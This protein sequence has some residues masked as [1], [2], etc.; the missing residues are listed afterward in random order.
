MSTS[1]KKF[2]FVSAVVAVIALSVSSADAA[3]PGLR[4]WLKQ[5]PGRTARPAARQTTSTPV[6]QLF[7]SFSYEPSTAAPADNGACT[8][9]NSNS[10][11]TTVRS[12]SFEPGSGPSPMAT[13]ST[14]RP[15]RQR[16][17]HIERKLHPGL[18]LWK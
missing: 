17:T 5:H 3:D 9:P 18:G 7:R 15:I 4:L 2:S 10:N 12:Y 13:S 11:G 16:T 6:T 8:F 14:A 1:V